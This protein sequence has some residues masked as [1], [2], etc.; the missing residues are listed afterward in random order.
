MHRLL[1]FESCNFHS[2]GPQPHEVAADA[3]L[4]VEGS[5]VGA[6]EHA[7]EQIEQT[8]AAAVNL[9]KSGEGTSPLDLQC[10]HV[11]LCAGARA[12][13]RSCVCVCVC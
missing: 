12:C 9:A 1:F 3:A 8:A 2:N 13:V 6:L 10:V 4:K 7:A 11:E 5:V